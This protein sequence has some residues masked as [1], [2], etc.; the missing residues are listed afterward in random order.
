MNP[1]INNNVYT[2]P[3]PPKVQ[4]TGMH[5][6]AGIGISMEIVDKN[7][8]DPLH[9][10]HGLKAQHASKWGSISDNL[11]NAMGLSE[12]ALYGILI[13]KCEYRFMRID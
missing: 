9:W 3:W 11:N 5:S 12:R 2:I 8:M 7:A 13:G 1:A 10:I 4:P 6:Q